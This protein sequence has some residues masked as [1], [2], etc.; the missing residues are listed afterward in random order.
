VVQFGDEA[1]TEAV[2]ECS[3]AYDKSQAIDALVSIGARYIG[4][5]SGESQVDMTDVA[6]GTGSVDAAGVPLVFEVMSDGSDVGTQVV[7]AIQALATRVP[8]E[9]SVRVRDDPTDAVDAGAAF[10]D[11]LEASSVGGYPDPSDPSVIC[12]SG[13]DVEDRYD[14]LD[15]RPDSFVGVLPGTPVCFDI[16]ARQNWTVAATHEPQSFPVDVDVLGDG[17][18]VLDTRDVYFLVPPLLEV[19]CEE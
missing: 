3:P 10:V 5:D 1:F 7:E 13:L 8:G 2:L 19:S 9:I 16:H 17:V 14:P 11:Y 12:V 15:G 6:V 18:T 4:V